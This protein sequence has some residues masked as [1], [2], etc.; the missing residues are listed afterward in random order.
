MFIIDELSKN[1]NDDKA[2]SFHRIVYKLAFAS[3]RSRVNIDLTISFLC[4]WISKS[5][6]EDWEMLRRM[7]SY[8]NYIIN[9]PGII[10]ANR[11]EVLLTW[12][13]VSYATHCDMIRHT[14]DIILLEYETIHDKYSK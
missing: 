12:V 13:D 9:M 3:K 5:T 11:F 4:T 2:E 8:T 6:K 1:L 7:L 10:E 14:G